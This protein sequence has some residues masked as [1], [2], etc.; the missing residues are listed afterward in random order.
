[1]TQIISVDLN[2]LPVTDNDLKIIAQFSNLRELNLNFTD[3]TG[4]GLKELVGL[5]HLKNLSLSGTNVDDKD[6]QEITD[7]QNLSQVTVWNTNLKE[8]GIEQLQNAG[9]HVNFIVGFADDGSPVQLT[10]PRLNSESA[11][12]E[13]AT[14]LDLAHPIFG[15]EIRYTTD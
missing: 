13:R 7:L 1:K 2:K 4:A 10:P 12:F 9:Q 11:V 6:L 5:K 14:P 15:V 8:T 3:I